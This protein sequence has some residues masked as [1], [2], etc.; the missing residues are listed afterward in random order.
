[1]SFSTTK[2]KATSLT[3]LPLFSS[4][5]QVKQSD[6][7]KSTHTLLMVP[8]ISALCTSILQETGVYGQID[9]EAFPMELI[10]L[11][12]D[13]LSMEVPDSYKSI[14]LVSHFFATSDFALTMRAGWRLL[15]RPRPGQSL[16]DL[17]TG[18]RIHLSHS[19]QGRCS[20]CQS[21][22]TPSRRSHVRY[23]GSSH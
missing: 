22:R 10:P 4:I 13:V 9:I 1:M 18:F 7:N 5:D 15:L 11:E 21:G 3:P 2:P 20:S 16:D 23:S 6:P 19:R 8:R 17:A 14:F 12:K